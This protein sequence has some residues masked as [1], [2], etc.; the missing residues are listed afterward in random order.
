[1]N[2]KFPFS[3]EAEDSAEAKPPQVSF[4]LGA[5][6][7]VEAKV[8]DTLQFVASFLES[9]QGGKKE[10]FEKF[11][12][13]L[14][15]WAKAQ[16]PPRIVDIE[17]LLET[18]QRIVDAPRDPLS[19][20]Y[21]SLKLPGFD[22]GELLTQLRDFVKKSVIV[23]PE[24]IKYLEPLRG[25]IIKYRPLTIYSANYDT[26]IE[27]FCSTH[28]LIYRDGFDE[29][30][31][32]EVFADP[33]ADV[34]LH[35]IHGSATWYRSDR[36]RYLKI[37]VLGLGSSVELITKERAESLILYPAQKFDYVEPLFELLTRMKQ[38]LA[39]CDILV[40]VGYSFRD[41][42]IRQIFWDIARQS[43]EFYVVLISPSARKIY[44]SQ[45]RTHDG[46]T[47]SSLA[48]RV[49]CLP[50]HFGKVL[51]VLLNEIITSV[52]SSRRTIRAQERLE[53]TGSMA[54]WPTSLLPTAR[55]GNY[56]DVRIILGKPNTDKYDVS[57]RLEAIVLGVIAALGNNDMGGAK[58][59][60]NAFRR[61][62]QELIDSKGI[63][64][65]YPHGEVRHYIDHNWQLGFM[66]LEHAAEVAEQRISWM[67]ECDSVSRFNGV[68]QQLLEKMKIWTNFNLS[69][70]DYRQAREG[71]CSE[72]LIAAMKDA[73]S[74]ESPPPDKRD[75]IRE[76][77][78]RTEKKVLIDGVL[79]DFHLSDN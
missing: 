1:M 15:K 49:L 9:L 63:T 60:M 32:P 36:G 68:L 47:P 34:L 70:S 45:L 26:C 53:L 66:D 48:D 14:E 33:K 71:F 46:E 21:S 6:A 19:A 58:Y 13:Q 74:G 25:F 17:L 2:N 59:F 23:A 39:T 40:V 42:H 30:W 75:L 76:E 65:G 67:G 38:G 77:I 22:A 64:S 24:A 50:Y 78:K 4:F 8:P 55:S 51:P 11:K 72:Q 57:F 5:G 37:P 12:N 79:G 35:K 62:I 18:L 31:N 44:E 20:F 3:Q 29:A 69:L 10:Q 27:L 73:E 56:E 7:S 52:I 43:K 28:R 61:I 54:N 41:D 16:N